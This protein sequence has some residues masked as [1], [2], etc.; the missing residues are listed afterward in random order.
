MK[1]TVAVLEEVRI[2]RHN[3][4]LISSAL[5]L[6]KIHLDAACRLSRMNARESC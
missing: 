4:L 6:P 2:H 1:H 3:I 5:K